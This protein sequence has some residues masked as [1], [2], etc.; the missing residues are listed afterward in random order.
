MKESVT[1]ADWQLF[2]AGQA[3]EKASESLQNA[4]GKPN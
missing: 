4:D 1:V 3:G 2:F